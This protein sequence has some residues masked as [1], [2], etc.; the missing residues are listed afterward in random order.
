MD[1]APNLSTTGGRNPRGM[2]Q[3][4][5][6]VGTIAPPK[7]SASGTERRDGRGSDEQGAESAVVLRARAEGRGTW[8]DPPRSTTSGSRPSPWCATSGPVFA[9]RSIG[10]Q[11]AAFGA[12]VPNAEC[13]KVADCG[14]SARD[15][16]KQI[17][18]S[19][20]PIVP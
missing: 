12:R 5:G 15:F 6:A 8:S 17:H 3:A 2:H 9:K 4:S 19:T 10:L 16:A 18:T 13:R 20:P 1:A 11:V 14:H 7:Q